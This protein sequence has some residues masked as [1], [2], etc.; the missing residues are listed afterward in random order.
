MIYEQFGKHIMKD[1]KKLQNE[2]LENEKNITEHL[3]MMTSIT[4]MTQK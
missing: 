3:Q 4:K 1:E 2:N